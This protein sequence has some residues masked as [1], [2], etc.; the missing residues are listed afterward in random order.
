[1]IAIKRMVAGSNA[2]RIRVTGF[3]AAE[4]GEASVLPGLALATR[5]DEA[6]PRNP[7]RAAPAHRHAVFRG[8]RS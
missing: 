8:S 1:M 2:G 5:L 4:P 3:S 6:R 7:I